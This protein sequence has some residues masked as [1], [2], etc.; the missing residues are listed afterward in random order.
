MKLAVTI[1]VKGDAL[2]GDDFPRVLRH[3]IVKH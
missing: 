3:I 2:I 1:P